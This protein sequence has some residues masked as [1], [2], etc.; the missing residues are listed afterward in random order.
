MN[1]IMTIAAA[2][3]ALGLVYWLLFRPWH[4]KWGASDEEFRDHLPGDDTVSHPRGEATHAITINAPA[5]AVWSWLVQMG[6]NKGGFYS[7][8]WLENLVGCHLRNADHILPQFQHLHVGDKVWLH[9]KAPPLPVLICDPMHSLVLGSNTKEP[10]LWGF[11]L[12]DIDANHVRLIVR[13][14]GDW[15]PSLLRSLIHYCVFEPAHF[16]MEQKM[17][18]GIKA[19][20]EQAGVEVAAPAAT[21]P[22]AS[23]PQPTRML[24]KD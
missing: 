17:M 22:N 1:M 20:A 18:R 8:S 24:I 23:K 6:Q 4:L 16:I 7:Y 11:F 9:P 19:R 10:G 14:R 5:S 12:K 2:S 13:W 21:G 15:K 3:L